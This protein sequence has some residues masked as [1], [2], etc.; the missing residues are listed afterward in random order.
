MR[1]VFVETFTDMWDLLQKPMLTLYSLLEE[2]D[3]VI[4]DKKKLLYEDI[5]KLDY[6]MLVGIYGN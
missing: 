5:A 4:G 3:N 1:V 2:V 6:M